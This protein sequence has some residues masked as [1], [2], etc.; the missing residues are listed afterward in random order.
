V[1]FLQAAIFVL[2]VD[3]APKWPD[4]KILLL[5][6]VKFTEIFLGIPEVFWQSNF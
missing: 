2:K 6:P 1:L 5:N 3:K 4:F